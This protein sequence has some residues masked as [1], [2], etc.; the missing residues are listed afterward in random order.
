[1]SGPGDTLRDGDLRPGGALPVE[2]PE[3]R[4]ALVP[5]DRLDPEG[6]HLAVDGGPDLRLA[7]GL[8]GQDAPREGGGL[9]VRLGRVTREGAGVDD[10]LGVVAEWRGVIQGGSCRARAGTARR[11]APIG[12]RT[13]SGTTPDSTLQEAADVP[14]GHEGVLLDPGAPLRVALPENAATQVGPSASSAHPS[15]LPTETLVQPTGRL[16]ATGGPLPVLRCLTSTWRS[17]PR[18]TADRYNASGCKA[19]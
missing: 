12:Q 16:P 13:S 18:R 6:E 8:L 14:H 15:S 10:R 3:H 19:P 2:E 11:R 4:G 7:R 9:A 1:M 17:L 5:V